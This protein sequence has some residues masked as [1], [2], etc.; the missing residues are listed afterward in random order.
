MLIRTP[1]TKY[2]QKYLRHKHQFLEDLMSKN[3]I[4]KEVETFHA[5]AVILDVKNDL[6][7]FFSSSEPSAGPDKK[8]KNETGGCDIRS[9]NSF[10][11]KKSLPIFFSAL[12]TPKQRKTCIK[13]TFMNK[14]IIQFFFYRPT[15]PIFFVLLQET[16]I[17]FCRLN[18]ALAHSCS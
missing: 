5:Y 13:H 3:D 7:L 1:T 8:S 15:Y 12:P 10:Y 4:A 2:S 18:E 6:I 9:K 11:S 14:K 17:F 16:N